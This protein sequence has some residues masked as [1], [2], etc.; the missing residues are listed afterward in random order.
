MPKK[1]T[2]VEYQHGMGPVMLT[3]EF[4]AGINP[5]G[6]RTCRDCQKQIPQVTDA[7]SFR[8]RTLW[9]HRAVGACRPTEGWLSR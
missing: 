6:T 4:V 8:R 2:L 1:I 3:P 5:D 9:N 7:E